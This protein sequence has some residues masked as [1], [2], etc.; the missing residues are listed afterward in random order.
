MREA[1]IQYIGTS[2]KLFVMK[3]HEWRAIHDLSAADF[4]E[5]KAANASAFPPAMSAEDHRSKEE[6][7]RS[8]KSKQAARPATKPTSGKKEHRDHGGEGEPPE[9]QWARW[10]EKNGMSNVP[11]K[12]QETPKK[13]DEPDG[14]GDHDGDDDSEGK[15]KKKKSRKKKSPS[16]P[17]SDEDSS[18]DDDSDSDDSSSSSRK[19]KKKKK[20]KKPKIKDCDDVKIENLPHMGDFD[21]W[22]YEQRQRMIIR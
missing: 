14:Q 7:L 13:P 3:V 5:Y 16:P 15:K 4:K 17:S 6:I 10:R 18:S 11:P 8:A 2:A 19:K 21:E 20:D 9:D 22:V 1:F 12:K